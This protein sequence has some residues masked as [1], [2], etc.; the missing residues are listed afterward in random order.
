MR[1]GERLTMFRKV[2]RAYI[3]SMIA[4][5]ICIAFAP[6]QEAHADWLSVITRQAVKQAQ[7]RASDRATEKNGVASNDGQR[8]FGGYSCSDDCSGHRAG[9]QWAKRNG[10]FDRRGCIGKSKSFIEGCMAYLASPTGQKLS[11]PVLRIRDAVV[12]IVNSYNVT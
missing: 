9:Y 10:I 8:T 11:R 6:S 7:E 1:A 4:T 12:A 2:R 5:A 3:V